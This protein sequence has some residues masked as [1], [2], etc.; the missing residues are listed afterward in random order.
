M[1]ETLPVLLVKSVLLSALALAVL[2][3]LSRRFAARRVSAAGRH[4][5]CVFAFAGLIA[6][7]VLSSVLPVWRVAVVVPPIPPTPFPRVPSGWEGEKGGARIGSRGFA[8]GGIEVPTAPLNRVA[9]SEATPALHLTP[10]FTP[11]H[12][13][14]TRGK[15]VGG[16]GGTVYAALTLALLA[17]LAFGHI[18]VWRMVRRATP[19]RDPAFGDVPVRE[20][21]EVAVPL[22]V[23]VGRRAVI[24]L[25]AGFAASA[26]YE[27]LQAVLAHE[28]AHV[29][30]GDYLSQTLADIVCAV[31]FANPLVWLLSGAMRGE[32]ERAADDRV[33]AGNAVRPSEYAAHLLDTV[34]CLRGHRGIPGS[35]VMM[36]RRSDVSGRVRTIL[37]AHV[38]RTGRVPAPIMAGVGLV[39]VVI[40][41]GTA[42]L[43]QAQGT[44][45]GNTVNAVPTVLPAVFRQTLADGTA[46]EVIAVSNGTSINTKNLAF[47]KPDGQ[48][49]TGPR[50]HT[51][52]YGQG[53]GSIPRSKEP[54][55]EVT[56]SLRGP[57][58][59]WEKFRRTYDVENCQSSGMT[60]GGALTPTTSLING[61]FKSQPANMNVRVG[62]A[63]TEWHTL[64]TAGGFTYL[65]SAS[66]S[67]NPIIDS[68]KTKIEIPSVNVA[69]LRPH[70]T[71]EGTVVTI[72]HGSFGKEDVDYRFV[73]EMWNGKTVV[74]KSLG[75]VEASDINTVNEVLIPDTP[76]ARIKAF[77]MQARTYDWVSFSGIAL[78]PNL[79]AP[80]VQPG[81]ARQV[82][83]SNIALP[84]STKEETANP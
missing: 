56:V 42:A 74:C 38:S 55:Y 45:P 11:S 7:P 80:Y 48:P 67:T 41:G 33:L 63:K 19:L 31:Y 3:L 71:P 57:R 24:V 23:G 5:V 62:V 13:E 16:I 36:A 21:P 66:T 20:S 81:T 10:S 54:V 37:A 61:Q 83:L 70:Q 59:N 82:A 47:W 29:Q 72:S 75:T 28:T 9:G 6:L 32:A 18:G 25:P 60:N 53:S 17:R 64:Y 4:L 26:T 68:G 40:V 43:R 30:R 65:N 58:S 22:T 12:P 27:R 15:G 52:P 46:V 39:G 50:P 49:I 44:V 1:N 34:R 8:A 14:G 69:L 76:V 35:A 84:L 77:R 79:P 51:M 73:A 78:R 2:V